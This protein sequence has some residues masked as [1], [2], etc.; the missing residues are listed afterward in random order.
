MPFVTHGGSGFSGTVET[1][2]KLQP[3]AAVDRNGISI[4]R[5]DVQDCAPDVSEWLKNLK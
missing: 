3:R 2:A 4:S 5:N 1:I